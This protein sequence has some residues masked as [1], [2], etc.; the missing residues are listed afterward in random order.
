MAHEAW[1]V[2][3]QRQ[4][5]VKPT[6]QMA[7]VQV[8][9]DEGLER[10]AD[11]MGGEAL[12]ANFGV[13][14]AGEKGSDPLCPQAKQALLAQPMARNYSAQ[15]HLPIPKRGE[16]RGGK[17]NLKTELANISTQPPTFRKLLQRRALSIGDTG[18]GS[19]RQ[20]LGGTVE[21]V[22]V[23]EVGQM[24]DDSRS[25]QSKEDV[26]RA[27]QGTAELKWPSDGEGVSFTEDYA[28]SVRR[29]MEW[30]IQGGEG[31]SGWH[32]RHYTAD[33]FDKIADETGDQYRRLD[34]NDTLKNDKNKTLVAIR[35]FRGPEDGTMAEETVDDL[36]RVYDAVKKQAE[37]LRQE[38]LITE[39]KAEVT[40]IEA[41]PAEAHPNT[42]P[43]SKVTFGDGDTVYFK[44][45]GS[46]VENALIG[47]NTSAA[48][49]LSSIGPETTHIRE[50]V[51]MHGFVEPEHGKGMV[52][53]AEDVG[54][55]VPPPL[56][57][58]S[59]GEW[60]RSNLPT[61][62]GGKDVPPR[63]AAIAAWLSAVKGALLASL[64]VTMDLHGSNIKAGR[65][66]KSHVIDAEVLLDVTQWETYTENL[67]ARTIA[68]FEVGRFTPPWLQK[69]M[70]ALSAGTKTLMAADVV[71]ALRNGRRDTEAAIDEALGPITRLLR[72][73]ALLRVLPKDTGL[74]TSTDITIL[75]PGGRRA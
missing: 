6:V 40:K 71:D 70:G 2:V 34:D 20:T 51:G 57:E 59:W 3:Q 18:A 46:A 56:P 75:Q 54:T 42:L 73:S 52:H 28:G 7:G 32:R 4:G 36:I 12:Q 14:A 72:E 5:R 35:A 29:A 25:V 45:R 1:H 50:G 67:K 58:V 48:S 17:S 65:T 69:H 62:L 44:G 53:F 15:Q 68:N 39:T 8:N 24:Q 13:D 55:E 41:D 27:R 31:T 74:P 66:G 33:S 38:H 22:E 30:G 21:Q 37:A 19:H 49:A 10:E 23:L 47:R 16:T 64:T 60:T 63:P 43:T 11:A 26:Q 9:D 61:I